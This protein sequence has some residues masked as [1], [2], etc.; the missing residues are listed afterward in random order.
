AAAHGCASHE[1]IA[2]NASSRSISGPRMRR[3]SLPCGITCW[4]PSGSACEWTIRD[5][6]GESGNT[7]ALLPPAAGPSRRD[8]SPT[9]PGLPQRD[10]QQLFQPVSPRV[11]PQRAPPRGGGERAACCIILQQPPRPLA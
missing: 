9:N 5:G 6:G 7:S 8:E 10:R 1:G 4:V 11:L 2:S 3:V